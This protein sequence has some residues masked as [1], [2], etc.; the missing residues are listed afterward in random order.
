MFIYSFMVFF[1]IDLRGLVKIV[2]D[3]IK[4]KQNIY[5]TYL[6]LKLVNY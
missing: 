2:V 1:S 3:A 6:F 4:K 5:I